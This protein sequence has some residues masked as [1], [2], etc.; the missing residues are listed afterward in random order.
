VSGPGVSSRPRPAPSGKTASKIRGG[1][2]TGRDHDVYDWMS[3]PRA[4]YVNNI[5]VLDHGINAKTG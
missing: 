2:W 5:D 1:S 4:D 3:S